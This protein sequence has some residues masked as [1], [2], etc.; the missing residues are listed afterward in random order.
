M[1]DAAPSNLTLT[2]LS[3][4]TIQLN[5]TSNASNADWS[6]I[7]RRADP[8][9]ETNYREYAFVPSSVTTFSDTK[10][11]PGGHYRYRIESENLGGWA[12]G[13]TGNQT[14]T[15]NASGSPLPVE[16]RDDSITVAP[17]ET[18]CFNPLL[19]DTGEGALSITGFTQPSA[20]SAIIE[21][22]EI[23]YTAPPSFSGG[24]LMTYN[25]VDSAG[26]SDTGTITF[27]LPLKTDIYTAWTQTQS[28]KGILKTGHDDD[29][30]LD[31]FS[32][33]LEFAFDLKPTVAEK[34]IPVKVGI[35]EENPS[36]EF[37]PVR[38]TGLLTYAWQFSADLRD[39]SS[40]SE[41]L[42]T[43]PP[44]QVVHQLLPSGAQFA[45]I[46]VSLR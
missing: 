39:W 26:Q 44:G 12:S 13:N 38:D 23:L 30:D 46:A 3:P 40:T 32:N 45:R 10:L 41:V 1:P 31:G 6:V 11:V 5:W 17:G 2:Q 29:P 14:L 9:G 33:L 20:G 8:D 15:L 22:N 7:Y 28:W 4:T 19:N 34:R 25:I 36:V 24:V 37:V 27:S 43:D 18:R 42:V 35:S 21:G 16:A